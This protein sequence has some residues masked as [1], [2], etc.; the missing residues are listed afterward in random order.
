MQAVSKDAMGRI[1]LLHAYMILI[2]LILISATCGWLVPA[3]YDWTGADQ[4]RPS[5]LMWQ[6]PFAVTVVAILF[7]VALPWVPLTGWAKTETRPRSQFNLRS[8]LIFTAIVAVAIA[9]GMKA[10]MVV[11]SIGILLAFVAAVRSAILYPERRLPIAALFAC[12]ILPFDWILGYKELDNL[13]PSILWMSFGMPGFFSMAM[14]AGL[15]GLPA[16]ESG[17]LAI[18]ITAAQ[19]TIGLWLIRVGSKSAIAFMLF[20]LLSSL[21][22]S[23]IFNALVR[24]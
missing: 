15:F 16:H 3:F 10:P 4:S 13:L 17:W 8:L 5:P 21:M 23:L 20:V 11:A 6:V 14:L 9:V 22:G 2:A 7:S 12:L 1:K 24:V 18:L 19:I